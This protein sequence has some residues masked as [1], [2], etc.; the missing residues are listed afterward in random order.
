[1]TKVRPISHKAGFFYG[2]NYANYKNKSAVRN[3]TVLNSLQF[4][5]KVNTNILYE[6]VIFMIIN[7]KV[8]HN[9][10]LSNVLVC[11]IQ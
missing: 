10:V 6:K 1:M 11:P 8:C 9:N 7:I 5:G 4:A 2:T 3:D